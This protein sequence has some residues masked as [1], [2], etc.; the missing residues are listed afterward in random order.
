MLRLI[1]EKLPEIRELCERYGVERLDLVGSAARE[2]DFDVTRSDVDFLV[3]W[4][5]ASPTFDGLFDL[6]DG[7]TECVGREVDVI[8]EKAVVNPY[9]L[10]AFAKDRRNLYGP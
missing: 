5:S 8:Q 6:R 1:E 2:V 3:R 7:L 9:R 4:S 10:A